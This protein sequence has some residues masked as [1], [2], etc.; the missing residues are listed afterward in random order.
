MESEI[1]K[2]LA[3]DKS[4][5]MVSVKEMQLKIPKSHKQWTIIHFLHRTNLTRHLDFEKHHFSAIQE[6]Q[7]SESGNDDH[8]LKIKLITPTLICIEKT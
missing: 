6:I 4:N 7:I 2:K 5:S 3:N 1:A 8:L